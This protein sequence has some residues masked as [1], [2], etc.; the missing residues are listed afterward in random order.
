MKTKMKR[1]LSYHIVRSLLLATA[2]SLSGLAAVSFTT[3]DLNLV[4]AAVAPGGVAFTAY[5]ARRAA[6]V[7]KALETNVTPPS[8]DELLQDF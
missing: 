5:W 1:Y 7:R 6:A 3:I 2:L 4:V 8:E